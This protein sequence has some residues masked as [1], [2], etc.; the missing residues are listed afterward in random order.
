MRLPTLKGSNPRP[1]LEGSHLTGNIRLRSADPIRGVI[2]TSGFRNSQEIPQ[3][4]V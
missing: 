1:D 3:M 2:E 4:A